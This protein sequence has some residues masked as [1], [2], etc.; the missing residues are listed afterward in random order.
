MTGHLLGGEA[1]AFHFQG[2]AS[3]RQGADEYGALVVVPAAVSSRVVV[4]VD[5]HVPPP[6]C[7]LGQLLSNGCLGA[8]R[9]HDG[10]S[11]ILPVHG[12]APH[13]HSG[14]SACHSGG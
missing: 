5:P 3:V 7:S 4:L 1:V 2:Q 14:E 8:V 13:T 9:F 12:T 11:Q 10:L 6:E